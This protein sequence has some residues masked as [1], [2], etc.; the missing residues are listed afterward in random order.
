MTINVSKQSREQ[1]RYHFF[2]SHASQDKEKCAWPLKAELEV[3]GCTV[4]IDDEQIGVGDNIVDQINEGLRESKYVIAI[5]SKD[6]LSKKWCGAEGGAATYSTMSD[7]H[8]RVLPIRHGITQEVLA[9]ELPLFGPVLSL[10]TKVPVRQLAAA[11]VRAIS[12]RDER[13]S[14]Q[15]TERLRELAGAAPEPDGLDALQYLRDLA[16]A[17]QRN[18][19]QPSSSVRQPS[20][21]VRRWALPILCCLVAAAAAASG[22]ELRRLALQGKTTQHQAAELLAQNLDF[23]EK[24][25]KR[26]ADLAEASRHMQEARDAEA[27]WNRE[28]EE[29]R[30]AVNGAKEL[31]ATREAE[32]SKFRSEANTLR[33]SNSALHADND[34]LTKTLRQGETTQKELADLSTKIRKEYEDH[35]DKADEA[36][37]ANLDEWNKEK[38]VLANDLAAAQKDKRDAETNRA[39]AERRVA[40]LTAELGTLKSRRTGSKVVDVFANNATIRVADDPHATLAR[41][42]LRQQGDSVVVTKPAGTDVLL[43]LWG[44]CL[45]VDADKREEVRCVYPAA[46]NEA[47]GQYPNLIGSR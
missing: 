11:L 39:K 32:I 27:Q 15:T 37:R 9:D 36:M 10:S 46:F 8:G 30:N 19:P 41:D 45:T 38:Q 42:Q 4:W 1:H 22:W 28:R 2:I 31:T 33:A 5:I 34:K 23:R 26:E 18:T 43:V 29:L 16:A 7:A 3:L 21:W 24:L 47:Q 12:Q 13:D 40:S 25:A 14:A 44:C 20:G 17:R 35:L 6:W